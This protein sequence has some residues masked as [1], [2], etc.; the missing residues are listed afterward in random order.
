MNAAVRLRELEE[1]YQGR[2]ELE[3]KSFLLR[4]ERRVHRDREAALEKFRSYTKGWQRIGAEPDAGEFETW[5]SD[6]GPPS[7]SVP[8]HVA[9]KA[10]ARLGKHAF[11]RIH[12]R[13][14][15]AYFQESRD[16]SHPAVLRE[17]WLE[18]GLDAEA[19][20]DLEDT[21]LIDE[22]VADHRE[23]LELGATGVPAVRL[24]D[25][26][27]VIVGAHPVELYR[28]WIERTLE[29]RDDAPEPAAK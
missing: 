4:P 20:P 7:H 13:L 12:A 19:F 25:N 11:E 9:S 6:E 17:L 1:E 27:A 10:A 28:R 2:V 26:P 5:H 8:A 24:E 29:R 22:I 15:R 3:W 14:L 21:A 23:A 18:V 16:V